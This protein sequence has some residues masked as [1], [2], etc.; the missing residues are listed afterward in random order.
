MKFVNADELLETVPFT[1]IGGD[2][3]EYTEGYLDCVR[4]AR[5]AIENAPEAI[6]RCRDCMYSSRDK[7]NNRIWCS[8]FTGCQE[9]SVNGYCHHGKRRER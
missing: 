4:E 9:T 3:S 5:E 7:E 6:T 8:Y 2:L 1:R